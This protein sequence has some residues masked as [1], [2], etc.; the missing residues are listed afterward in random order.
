MEE[1]APRSVEELLTEIESLRSRLG[2][3]AEL[4]S[5]TAAADEALR[6]E[7]EQLLSIFDSINEIIYVS[8]PH[9]YEILF[10]N[11]ATKEAFG[12][13]PTGG[14][15]YR[16]FQNFDAP[17][18]FCTNPII[19]ASPGKPYSWEYHN[20]VLDRYYI[21]VDRI[22]RWPDGR[23]VRFELALD[24]TQIRRW[25]KKREFLNRVYL[26]LGTDT[27][28][29][30]ERLVK[31]ARDITESAFAALCLLA[32][33]RL[34][35]LTTIPG[36]GGFLVTRE[37]ERYACYRFI[38]EGSREPLPC[39]DPSATPLFR[40]DPLCEEQGFRSSLFYPVLTEGEVTGCLWV[41]DVREREW[42]PE[43]VE[44]VGMLAQALSV[45]N[46]R[47]HREEELKDFIDVASHELRHP[48]TVIRGY[49]SSL[50]E[51][52]RALTDEQREEMLQAVLRGSDRLTRLINE[53]LDV[54]RIERG[55]FRLQPMYVR[56]RPILERAVEET[57]GKGFSNPISVSI[58]Q[59]IG[60]IYADPEKLVSLL[61]ILLDNAIMFSAP[62]SE[63]EV[64][65]ERKEQVVLVSVLDRGVGIPDGMRDRV[66]ER[67]FQVE[68]VEHHSVPGLGMGLYIAREI[69]EGHG[70]RI[71]NEPRP[72]GGT[73]FRFTLPVRP[74]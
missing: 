44:L 72:G 21:I 69:V 28:A 29:N 14:L 57:H 11:R 46:E 25:Q 23:D 16:E 20:P 9:T 27:V 34:S 12:K 42:P 30:M 17:C 26:G 52:W 60:E 54:S 41:A 66:F 51:H 67:F 32:G 50:L 49:A 22:I 35:L 24:V 62:G 73:V 40:G 68:E 5:R 64:T 43:E 47:L 61:V 37:K 15:C 39:A 48:V 63:V 7:R 4:A 33:G 59:D 56:L 13:D 58:T 55:R 8:D 2:E 45:E 10:V 31:A 6:F 65:A 70:G 71:W 3:L 1:K 53:L 18:E 74:A 19:L 38:I 36:E